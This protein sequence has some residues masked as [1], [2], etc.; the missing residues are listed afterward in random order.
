MSGRL[1]GVG[2]G[3]GDP[4]LMTLKA[5]RL[6]SGAAVVA[7]PAL[8]GGASFARSIAADSLKE[9]AREIVIEMPMVTARAPAQAAYDKA[10]AEISEVL[11]GGQDVVVLC[12][13]DPLFYGSF[14]YLHARLKA[15]FDCVVVPGVNSI[16]ASAAVAGLPLVARNAVLSVLPGPMAA[17]EMAARI[18]AAEAVAIMKV[19]RHLGKIRDVLSGLGLVEQAI[20]VERASLPEQRVIPLADAPDEAPYF[21]MILVNKGADPWL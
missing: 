15:R 11:E 5:H 13:G 3:P 10:A 4:E 17:A 20:Y 8:I 14:M 21:S 19:G 12:E 16:N 18:D 1:Y 9:G 6:I 2:L 7:Y